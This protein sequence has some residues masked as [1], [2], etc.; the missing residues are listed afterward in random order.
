[1]VL[2]K[3]SIKL[4]EKAL[5]KLDKGFT[6]PP[7]NHTC[8]LEMM[9]KILGHVAEKMQN[10]YPY[11]HPLFSGQML[12]PPHPIARTAYALAMWI[13]RFHSSHAPKSDTV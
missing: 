9:G 7:L 4:L 13:N 2:E 12:K 8:D 10:N 11:F 3:E 6:L 5:E 1:M